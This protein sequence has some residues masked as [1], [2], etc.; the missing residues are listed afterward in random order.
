MVQQANRKSL[1]KPASF[2]ALG[3]QFIDIKSL[4]TGL[5]SEKKNIVFSVA[6]QGCVTSNSFMEGKKIYSF[7]FLFLMQKVIV[8][9]LFD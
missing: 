6:F 7:F 2:V 9:D 8:Y 5:V 1:C 4:K 3:A